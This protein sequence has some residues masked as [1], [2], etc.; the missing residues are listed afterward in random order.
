MN[1]YKR[2]IDIDV[3]SIQTIENNCADA[4]HRA[5]HLKPGAPRQGNHSLAR[6]TTTTSI[7]WGDIFPGE[8]TQPLGHGGEQLDGVRFGEHIL[9]IGHGQYQPAAKRRARE[10]GQWRTVKEAAGGRYQSHGGGGRFSIANQ[11]PRVL[12]IQAMSDIT[13]IGREH[14]TRDMIAQ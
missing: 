13:E 11:P 10:H 7:P 14:R 6:R 5:S 9:P 1:R 3:L 8:I 12:F 4:E 2:L